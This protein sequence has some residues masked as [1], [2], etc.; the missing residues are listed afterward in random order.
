MQLDLLCLGEPLAELNQQINGT[1]LSGHGGDVSNCAISAARQHA[2]VGMLAH[3]GAD[4][5]GQDFLALWEKEHID[6]TGVFQ[7]QHH[8]TGMYSVT[9]SDQGHDFQYYRKGSASAM[10]RPQDLPVDVLK[11][12]RILHVSG[13]SQA[14]STSAA[15]SVFEAI[16]LVRNAGGLISYDSNL[17]LKL[18]PLR[19]ARAIIHEAMSQCDIA[20]PGLDDA[21]MLT[22]FS[23]PDKIV[24]F[25]LQNGAAIVAL[26]LGAKG[27]LVATPDKRD[28]IA[29]KSVTAVD[30][31]GAGDT[32][33]GAF[34]AEFSRH[35][36][37]FKA[38]AYANAAAGLAVQG[39]GAVAPMPHR[40]QVEKFLDA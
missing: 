16:D 11:N 15:D 30:A 38:A 12:T 31:T 39:Y 24:D 27:T 32:F 5:F 19:R 1:Y 14:I 17:R 9:H 3:V 29:G 4:K 2:K 34:L 13:I 26:T 8:P 20:L 18:W 6:C 7:D 10:M 33:D 23:N 36:D 37:P 28:M 35:Q 22:G 25:Y 21:E 40:E